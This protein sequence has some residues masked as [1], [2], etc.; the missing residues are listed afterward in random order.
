MWSLGCTR[1]TLRLICTASCSSTSPARAPQQ[2]QHCQQAASRRCA[3][4]GEDLMHVG[5]SS[6]G[7]KIGKR[8]CEA[9]P[10]H[11]EAADEVALQAAHL[12]K[13]AMK[14]LPCSVRFQVRLASTEELCREM[15]LGPTGCCMHA[16]QA[17]RVR[18]GRG[19]ARGSLTGKTAQSRVMVRK[20][21]SDRAGRSEGV[22][23]AQGR[24]CR[25]STLRE[26][27]GCA[28]EGLTGK[29]AQRGSG[30]A[31]RRARARPEQAA[32]R[33]AA[34]TAARRRAQQGAT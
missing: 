32:G 27:Q 12:S 34:G 15:L 31:R 9:V 25:E 21:G 14:H 22:R 5:A 13:Q 7:D 19:A 6:K 17:G 28:R 23:G 3:T 20:G 18:Q 26:G 33:A 29:Y 4:Q 11:A 2:P 1:P 8:E 30:C 16:M 10:W 24:V